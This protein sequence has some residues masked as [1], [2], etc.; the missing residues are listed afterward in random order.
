MTETDEACFK[1]NVILLNTADDISKVGKVLSS[2]MRVK[3]LALCTKNLPL[4][5][6]GSKLNVIQ[7]SVNAALIW[8]EKRVP[9]LVK[10]LET[11]GGIIY[12][13]ARRYL[14]IDLTCAG[15]DPM[16]KLSEN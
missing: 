2:I 16:A 14:L 12:H 10:R 5:I 4:K 8:I 3:S 11:P 13:P 9:W 1:G 15:D 7:N 6:I